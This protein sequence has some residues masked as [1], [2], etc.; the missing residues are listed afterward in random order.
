M[1]REKAGLRSIICTTAAIA[2]SVFLS[3]PVYAAD[4]QSLI[5]SMQ[6]TRGEAGEV[7][8]AEPYL[9]TSGCEITNYE[10]D[11]DKDSWKPGKKVGIT[12]TVTADEGSNFTGNTNVMVMN[13]EKST[14][15]KKGSDY[16]VKI[17]YTP[18]V[19]LAQ[20]TGIRYEDE[21]TLCW[22]EVQYAGGYEVQIKKDGNFYKTVSVQG[23][24]TT[25]CDLSEYTTD[26]YLYT[27]SVRAVAPSNKVSVITASDWVNFDDDG[28]S[29]SGQSTTAGEFIGT[30]NYRQFLD[31]T[32]KRAEG[33]QSIG[34]AWYYFDPNN[35]FYAVASKQADIS[36]NRYSFDENG[37]MIMGWKKEADGFWYYYGTDT[38][39]QTPLGAART[40]WVQSA[41]TSP[42]YYL[43]S[44]NTGEYPYGAML[45]NTTTPDGYTVNANGEWVQ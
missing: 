31:T 40:G 6:E 17:N 12:V 30:G 39:A 35:N 36:G 33:W 14:A 37:R 20:P 4:I 18:K 28:V 38:N 21:S 15:K 16:T 29:M 7:W 41:P 44:G 10:W 3:F 43:S 9:S 5:I 1:K 19:Q 26:D 13:G 34:G 45:V 42:W 25:E 32:G 24:D 11:Y 2:G 27:C 22:E 23:K 8:E